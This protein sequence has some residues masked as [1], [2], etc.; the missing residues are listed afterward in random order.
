[1]Y[2]RLLK[3]SPDS[4]KSFFLF[5]PRGTGKT[6]WVRSNFSNSLYLDLLDSEIYT[7]LQNNPKHLEELIPP[8]FK[9]W[10][11]LDEVQ[12]LPSL[13]NEIHRLIEGYRFKFILTG[14][15]ARSLRRRGVNLLAGR[16]LHYSMYPLTA[17]ELGEDFDLNRAI[18]YGQ[19]PSI[20]SEPDPAL[21][22]KTYV[23]TYLREEVLQEGL[24][25]NLGIFS[26]FLETASFSQGSLLNTSAIAR[27]I[28]KDPKTVRNFFDLLEDLLLGHRLTIFTKR[29]KRKLVTHPKFYFFDVGVYRSLRPVG[30][31]D[32]PEEINGIAME[33]F[34]LQELKAINDYF[35]LDYNL[36]FW[37]TQEGIE[38]DFIAY[39]EKGLIAFEVKSKDYI[40]KKDLKNLKLFEKEYPNAKL[41]LIYSG[42]LKKY[43]DNIE[44]IPISEAVKSLPRLLNY[45]E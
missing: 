26:R 10:V 28:G 40:D 45:E 17:I 1:M 12:K 18:H 11:I 8:Q 44:I 27:E 15:S 16:A 21:Y 31:L 24:T 39:G 25:R 35:Q 5:S 6:S 38:V 42:K 13:L 20:P 22:L 37:R 14:S 29:A 7:T 43:V 41:Y 23:K 9:G 30:P 19:L 33:S 4:P 34:F 2:P 36:Y 32:V 3:I